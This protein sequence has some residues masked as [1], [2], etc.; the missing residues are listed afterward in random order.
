MSGE[1]GTNAR[2]DY[3]WQVTSFPPDV[4]GALCQYLTQ[5]GIATLTCFLADYPK[6]KG[7]H[8]T[9]RGP[10]HSIARGLVSVRAPEAK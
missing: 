9:G 5:E 3:G 7:L 8:P 1:P 4:T 2:V 6:A 10:I